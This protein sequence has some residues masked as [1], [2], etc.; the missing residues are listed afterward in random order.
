M[1]T[2][3]LQTLAMVYFPLTGPAQWRCW[4]ARIRN[5]TLRKRLLAIVDVSDDKAVVDRRKQR[6]SVQ[7]LVDCEPDLLAQLVFDLKVFLQSCSF[8]PRYDER[9][10]LN[11]EELNQLRTFR[12]N[13]I[14]N[15]LEDTKEQIDL[16]TGYLHDARFLS[17]AVSASGDSLRITINRDC[18]EYPYYYNGSSLELHIADSDVVFRPLVSYEFRRPKASGAMWI[19]S[20]R[21]KRKRGQ[22]KLVE[23]VIL[24]NTPSRWTIRIYLESE[25]FIAFLMDKEYP[26]LPRER[27]DRQ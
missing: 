10:S 26:H 18:W 14:V 25:E 13:L 3:D 19:A 8:A 4:A 23:V 27:N 12:L 2:I 7:S 17:E 6:G 9:H 22:R 16:F 5:P 21:I 15:G 24:G 20:A 1:N 11:K